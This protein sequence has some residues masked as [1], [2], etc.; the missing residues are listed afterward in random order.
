VSTMDGFYVVSSLLCF[1]EATLCLNLMSMSKSDV[2]SRV[3]QVSRR[4]AA[5]GFVVWTSVGVV[6]AFGPVTG[7]PS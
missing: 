2:S 5:I 1:L 3:Y 6:F 7:W 4:A